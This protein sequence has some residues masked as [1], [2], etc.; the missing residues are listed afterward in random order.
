MALE[1]GLHRDPFPWTE[2]SQSERDF[3]H[4]L[5]WMVYAQDL[6]SASI[7]G[8]PPMIRDSDYDVTL[9]NYCNP[10]SVFMDLF[11]QLTMIL[12]DIINS[13]LYVY[14]PWDAYSIEAVA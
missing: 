2:I 13:L 8:H 9:Y 3:R 1:L 6:W 10:A 5:W 14:S 4:H 7:A 12:R 11:L